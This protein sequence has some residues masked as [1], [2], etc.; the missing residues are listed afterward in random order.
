MSKSTWSDQDDETLRLLWEHRD[1]NNR[2]ISTR[3]IG[4]RMK[5]TKNAIVGRAGRMRLPARASPIIRYNNPAPRPSLRTGAVSLPPLKS[6]Q[7]DPLPPPVPVKPREVK[8]PVRTFSIYAP[9][10]RGTPNI[11]P[12]VVAPPIM[13]RTFGRVISCLW[14]IGEPGTKSFRFCDEPSKAGRVYCE[15]HYGIAYV[16]IPKKRDRAP[17]FTGAYRSVLTGSTTGI[18]LENYW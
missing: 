18:G 13:T 9:K 11:R 8:Q 16:T 3:E 2:T 1:V 4:L 15:C 12:P 5:R 10:P 6:L 14:P 7:T 17:V